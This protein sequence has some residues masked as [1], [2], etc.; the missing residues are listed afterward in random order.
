MPDR[1]FDSLPQVAQIPDFIS[2]VECCI[3]YFCNNFMPDGGI[4]NSFF[5]KEMSPF[6]TKGDRNCPAK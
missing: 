6:Y 5:N 4:F 2:L 1:H 3:F